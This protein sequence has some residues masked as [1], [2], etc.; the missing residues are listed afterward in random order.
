MGSYLTSLTIIPVTGYRLLKPKAEVGAGMGLKARLMKSLHVEDISDRILK[1]YGSTL[2]QA[3]RV[4]GALILFFIVLLTA[5]IAVIPQLGVQLFPPV[6]RDQYIIDV[7]VMDGSNSEK[8]GEAVSKVGAIL[9]ADGSVNSFASVVGDGMLKYYT[10]F[11]P[12]GL[13]S[14]KAQLLVSGRRSEVER[15]E[16]ELWEKANLVGLTNY[17][18]ASTVRMAV[19]GLE[20]SE[21]KEKYIEILYGYNLSKAK[22]LNDIACIIY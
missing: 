3:L 20:I 7:K 14:N 9:D 11:M 15:L 16:R 6:D 21:L 12:N 2:K 1:L 22:Y 4:P 13:A 8:T 19:N 18:I 17:D 5:S 10:S